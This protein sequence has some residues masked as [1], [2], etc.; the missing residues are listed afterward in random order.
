MT[1]LNH[2]NNLPKKLELKRD[3]K[4]NLRKTN[5]YLTHEDATLAEMIRQPLT[6]T[7]PIIKSTHLILHRKKGSLALNP[8]NSNVFTLR[9]AFFFYEE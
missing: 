6:K 9:E 2:G 3:R 1:I 5:N 4:M 8:L 7:R